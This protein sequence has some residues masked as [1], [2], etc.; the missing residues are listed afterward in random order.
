MNTIDEIFCDS[1]ERCLKKADFF[2]R[3]YDRYISSNDIVAQKF[4]NTDMETQKRMLGASLHM[5]MSLSKN[6]SEEATA[7]FERIGTVHGRSAHNIGPELYDLW[8]TCL[9]QAV[10]EC[11]SRYDTSVENA[12]REILTGGIKIMQSMY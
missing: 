5:L 8:M 4:A 1:Y 3:F 2:D 6:D 11:D 12:W 10:E 7:Y 9:L